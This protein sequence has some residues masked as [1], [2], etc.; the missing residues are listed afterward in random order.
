MEPVRGLFE[1]IDE[2]CR[3]AHFLFKLAKS[4]VL[5]VFA[6]INAALR[7][8]PLES[9]AAIDATAKEY[10][11]VPR[12]QGEADIRAIKFRVEGLSLHP[13]VFIG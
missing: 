2:F 7:H 11:A 9:P 12:E 4:G 3:H 6:F 1:D 13:D 8:L 5:R 10:V